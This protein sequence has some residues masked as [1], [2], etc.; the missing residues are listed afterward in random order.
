V[1]GFQVEVEKGHNLPSESFVIALAIIKGGC[2]AV[3]RDQ[4]KKDD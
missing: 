1:Y 2:V 3:R 4:K